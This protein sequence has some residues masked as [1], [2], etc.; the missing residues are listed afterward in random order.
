MDYMEKIIQAANTRLQHMSNGQYYLVM[1]NEG[2]FSG[3]D[4]EVFDNY[5]GQTRDVN[6]MSG[7][8]KFNASLSLAL[9]MAD[10]IQAE[11]GGVSLDTMFIDEGFGTLD[12][13]SLNMALSTLFEL[14]QTGRLIGL[15]S[16]VEEL[17]QAMP[18]V[19]E[20]KKTTN[21]NSFTSFVL[22]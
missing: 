2:D 11:H 5:I 7:G 15:I 19:L 21:G 10:V 3:L 8:E 18:A 4:F 6:S 22:K 14:Q 16:H 20:V 1:K 13:E 12:S 17:K 9:G